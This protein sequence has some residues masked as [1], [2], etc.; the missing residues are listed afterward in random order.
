MPEWAMCHRPYKCHGKRAFLPLLRSNPHLCEV[1]AN[2]GNKPKKQLFFDECAR[3]CVGEG[4]GLSECLADDTACLVGSKECRINGDDAGCERVSVG[5]E[6]GVE[7]FEV[8]ENSLFGFKH[9]LC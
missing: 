7:G 4:E 6:L 2:I 3:P 5:F 8:V 1:I 9:F